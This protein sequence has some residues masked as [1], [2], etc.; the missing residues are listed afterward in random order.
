MPAKEE[1]PIER[2]EAYGY[3]ARSEEV[4]DIVIVTRT[5]LKTV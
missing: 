5:Y 2:Q 3:P 1:H 4:Q